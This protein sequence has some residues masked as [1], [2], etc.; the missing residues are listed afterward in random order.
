LAEENSHDDEDERE[1]EGF[2]RFADDNDHGCLLVVSCE[3]L[4]PMRNGRLLP[5]SRPSRDSSGRR[6]TLHEAYLLLVRTTAEMGFPSFVQFC[7]TTE[8]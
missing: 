3:A 6:Q 1:K 5:D 7:V 8:K 2:V 4:L